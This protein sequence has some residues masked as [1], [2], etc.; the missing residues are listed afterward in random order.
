[1]AGGGGD[2]MV[3]APELFE[4]VDNC[5]PNATGDEDRDIT[6]EEELKCSLP[7]A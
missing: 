7:V 4:V 1:M 5:R 3:A 6:G 2:G